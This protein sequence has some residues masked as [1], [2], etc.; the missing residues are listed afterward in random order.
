MTNAV[1]ERPFG[2]LAP[3]DPL[4]DKCVHCG[5]CLSTCPSYLLLGNEMDSP[6]GRIYM[7]KA[8]VES[9]AE[10]NVMTDVVVGHFDTCLGCMACE[11]AC[12]SG[13]R[14][15]PLIEE[16]RA[17][18]EHHYQRPA[19]ERL[20]RRL[21]FLLLPYPARLRVFALPLVF[22]NVL[23]RLPALLK[24]LPLKL[25]NLVALAPDTRLTGSSGILR[26]LPERTAAA[27]EP[28]LRVG[29]LTGCV[30]RVFF[31]HV[32]EAT[33]RVLAAEGCEVVAPRGQGCC[34][35]LALHSGLDEEAR[36][37]ARNLIAA[38]DGANV[39][40]V[41]VNA[42]GCGS[43]MKGYGELLQHDPVWAERAR[44]FAAKV[45]DVTEVVAGF[46]SARAPRHRLDVRVAYHDACHL[47]HAQGVRQPPRDVLASIPGVTV[48]PIGDSEICCGSAG[49]FNLVQPEMAAE[50]GRRKAA[51]IADA[52]PDIIATTNPGCILQ[53]GAAG[54][55]AG[56]S[57]PVFHV[58]ELLDASIRGQ[59]L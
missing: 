58:V 44:A 42:A 10:M 52:R 59:H 41:V 23:R 12:P 19:G 8:G 38:F 16:T 6:R 22:V 37:F 54:R 36:G 34:G 47:A 28:R 2:S 48:V 46:G 4:I 11:T 13:V 33:V 56:D 40:T 14:Y 21:L 50:L 55:A 32:N 53:I 5:F 7:M 25:S 27:G 20:F 18:I 49:I 26:S 30:Q 45:R 43:T 39:D 29:L 3:L 24:L 35:A 1:Q 17:A 51:K 57:R 9:R 31:G 15:A